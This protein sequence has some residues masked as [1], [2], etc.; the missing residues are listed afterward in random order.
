M[1]NTSITLGDC[2]KLYNNCEILCFSGIIKFLII[3]W[4]STNY[5][6]NGLYDEFESEPYYFC[7]KTGKLIP[8][9]YAIMEMPPNSEIFYK[10]A[11]VCK[12]S[13]NNLIEAEFDFLK[14]QKLR[15]Q[16]AFI[17]MVKPLKVKT[18]CFNRKTEICKEI[19]K[20]LI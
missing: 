1:E 17:N 5:C 20:F 4:S 9:P 15:S 10:D 12:P 16:Y 3:S 2:Q 6:S 18:N 7:F 8:V 11:I 19:L 14:L 13:K